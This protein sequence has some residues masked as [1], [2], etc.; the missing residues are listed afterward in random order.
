MALV[1]PG[2]LAD[3]AVVEDDLVAPG[4]RVV[5]VV[6]PSAADDGATSCAAKACLQPR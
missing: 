3:V 4:G 6:L 2:W 1:A 5:E